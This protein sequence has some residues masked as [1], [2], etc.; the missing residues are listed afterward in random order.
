MYKL[1]RPLLFKIE[2]DTI[3][4]KTIALGRLLD[5]PW[6]IKTL[7]NA[8]HFEHPSLSTKVFGLNFPNPVGLPPG[9]DRHA[10]LINVLPAL[11]FGF[12]E[13]C[14]V[15]PKPQEG[16]PKPRLFRL[17]KDQALLNRIGFES[18]GVDA[19]ARQLQTK[20]NSTILGVGITRNRDTPNEHA[21]ADYEYC[22]RV[23]SDYVDFL[24]I[25]VSSPNTP[26]LRELQAKT[27]LF[28]I[29]E[30]LQRLNAAK[31]KPIPLLFKIS[32]DLDAKQLD[33]IITVVHTTRIAGVIATNTTVS[34]ES[35]T[36]PSTEVETLGNGG[37][38]GKPLRERSTRIIRYLFEHSGGAFPIIGV[39]GIFSAADAYEK[40]RA[41]ASLVQLYTG[42]A[43]EGPGLV[44]NIKQGLVQLLERDGFSSLKEAVGSFPQVS[45]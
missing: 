38:S 7:N 6:V 34:R 10:K 45:S 8:F 24:V 11:G 42:L 35:L 31:K 43:Y 13:I 44:K 22:F 20:T 37:I 17:P 27:S 26:Y 28:E 5:K 25:N 14:T 12:L 15:T 19:V 32:P 16:N 1:I 23:I 21:L 29:G 2:P 9:A 30:R 39:G 40:I 4:E 41:G 33:D 36:T 18:P 3:H